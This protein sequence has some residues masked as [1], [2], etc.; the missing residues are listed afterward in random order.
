MNLTKAN[1]RDLKK[2]TVKIE[3][4]NGSQGTGTMVAV[5]VAI[6]VLTAA[7][8]IEEDTKGGHL[9]KNQIVVSQMR[10]S[11]KIVF[12]VEDV[13]YY[14][15]EDDAS[16]MLVSY[17][18]DMTLSG[19]DKVMLLTTNV[20][21]PAELC[22]FHKGENTPK[23]HTFEHRGENCWA[24]VNIQLK[25]QGLEPVINF[26]GTS[27]GGIFYQDS[28]KVLYM[29]AYMSEVGRYDGNNNEFICMPSSNFISSGLLDDIVDK[30]DFE[31]IADSGIA[32]NVDSRQ[33]FNSLDHSGYERNQTGPFIENERT[34]EIVQLLRDDDK[35]TL[36]LTALS[37]MGKSKLIY[38]AFRGTEREP[39]RYY[40]K[41]DNNQEQL[42][43]EL[44]Q[45]LRRN[46]GNDGIII[47]D[48][49]PM[50]LVSVLISIRNQY[51]E[52]FRLIMVHHDFFNDELDHI[53]SFPVIKLKPSEMLE[54]VNQY[55]SEVLEESENNKNDIA[56][57]QKL[58]E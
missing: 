36:L 15:S 27:G 19:I 55:I 37:G 38:E 7:H 1:I 2:V 46:D 31:Y 12:K 58:A 57:I 40:A 4:S 29:S 50:E 39:N 9:P 25:T 42:T 21:G 43:G 49:C 33:L 22:G 54:Q 6:Y 35:P 41:Y 18:G 13:V 23:L 5:G 14:N 11:Q 30:R 3:C 20:T 47:V 17:T 44:K 28:T 45:I 48:D 34:K 26:E 10:N 52:Q 16:V 51:N 24:I 8:V 53:N 32:N 56:E